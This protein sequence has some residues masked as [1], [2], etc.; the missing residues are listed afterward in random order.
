MLQ[1]YLSRSLHQ[2]SIVALIQNTSPVREVLVDEFYQDLVII[3][4][5]LC[6]Q[7]FLDSF[8][9]GCCDGRFVLSSNSEFNHSAT[10]MKW[11]DDS[12]FVVAG[13]DESAVATKL[14]N[15]RP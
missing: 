1:G 11:F 7:D 12:I 13:E 8:E 9:E 3:F 15:R 4:N 2:R 6:I 10:G 14:L 5:T